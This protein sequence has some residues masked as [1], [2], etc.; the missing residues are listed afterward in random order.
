MRKS[1]IVVVSSCLLG[2]RVRYDGASKGVSWIAEQ[3]S[4]QVEIVAICPEVGAGMPVPRPPI[5][6]VAKGDL[7]RVQEV[8]GKADVTD[9][10]Q[11]YI[12][13]QLLYLKN[14]SIDG[15][16]LKARSPSCGVVDTPQYR[17][18]ARES[19]VVRLGGGLWARALEKAFPGMPIV[20]ESDLQTPK[21]QQEFLQE[22]Y[23]Y[24]NR[25]KTSL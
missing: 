3:L 17:S 11:T 1:P 2:Q 9:A 4:K 7:L 24:R 14:K 18:A 10:L 25:P 12:D 23:A 15:A 8:G 13:S 6:V 22:L 19:E 5:Q 21:S 16:V 20:D